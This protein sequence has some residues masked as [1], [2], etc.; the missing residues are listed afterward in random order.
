MY[1]YDRVPA[2]DRWA[3]A[4]YIRALQLS[5]YGTPE[6]VPAEVQLESLIQP[7]ADR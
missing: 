2:E 6:D 7:E 4:G 5:Q 1:P 3:I